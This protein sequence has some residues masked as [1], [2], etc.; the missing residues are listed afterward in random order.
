MFRNEIDLDC[1]VQAELELCQL[2]LASTC[3]GILMHGTDGRIALFNEACARNLGYT[4]EEFA[5][6]PPFG[7]TD[8]ASAADV[9]RRV[10][11]MRTPEG[12]TFQTELTLPDGRFVVMEVRSRVAETRFGP[13]VVSVSH[14]ITERTRAERMLHDL[15][16]HDPLTGLANRV[17]FDERLDAAIAS[18]QR[19]GD[20][21][22][23][24]YL[25]I[26]DF[27]SINDNYGHSAGDSV[28]IAIARRL[29]GAV[30]SEDVVAR[31]GGD[32]FV[33]ILPR[34]DD[35]EDLERVA[36]KLRET[37]AKRLK[38]NAALE[39]DLGA[40]TGAALYNP[41]LDDA[42]SLVA[43]ADIAMY[44]SKRRARRV[45]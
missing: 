27:K 19:H 20:C 11:R 40:A 36:A 4:P 2:A 30:R 44:E 5:K 14:D 13:L 26:D 3:E 16:F 32:E 25:D 39:F 29:E 41:A 6:L 9:E 24:I 45:P 7:W 37:V 10:E 31:L 15:A 18:A 17:A 33:V 38:V 34:L 28:L 42:R 1:D 22:G 23:V 43:R 12:T 21:L 35:A 8:V